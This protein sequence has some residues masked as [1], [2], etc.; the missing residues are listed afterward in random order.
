M[1][2]KE[3]YRN[4]EIMKKVGICTLFTGYN[5][6]SSLQAFAL[7][8]TID[9]LG[10]DPIIFKLS[11]SLVKGRDVRPKKMFIT[12]F[13]MLA[14]SR[15]IRGTIKSFKKNSKANIA[16]STIEAFNEFTADY[17]N[18]KYVSY[19]EIKKLAKKEDYA[20]FVCGSDQIWN[21]TAYYVDP[22]YYLRF[23]PKE[24]RIAYAP[25]FGRTYVPNYNKNKISK[26]LNEI[27]HISVRETTGKDIVKEIIDKECTVCLDPTLLLNKSDWE[28]SFNLKRIN[29]NYIF[30]YFLDKP[31]EK[32]KKTIEI[33]AKKTKC[34]VCYI[35]TSKNKLE[36]I[37]GGPIGFLNYILNAQ[38]VLTDSFHGVAFSVNFN[39]K[40]I[41]F[42]R[43]YTTEKTQ[44]TRI[45]SLLEKLNISFLFDTTN[46]KNIDSID[47]QKVN[48]ILQ[49][50]RKK[51]LEYLSTS[52]RSINK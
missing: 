51:S 23:A 3:D 16:P 42:D 38:Y 27:N 20:A 24:K 37:D 45:T 21:S 28:N 8:K 17:L 9:K 32:A 41:V 47:Y 12:F 18:P 35:N 15:D 34:Q 25:S 22:F 13:R 29:K 26:Y 44:S 52:I 11:G 5:Y 10:Y 6:G 36:G 30:C 31:T 40:F 33:L 14:N 39:K 2:L 43:A 48:S 4:G 50:E 1:Q 46:I 7:K 49:E 19:R